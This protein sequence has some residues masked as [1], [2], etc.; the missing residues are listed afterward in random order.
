MSDASPITCRRQLQQPSLSRVGGQMKQVVSWLAA[1]IGEI[2]AR[3]APPKRSRALCRYTAALLAE[4]RVH[5]HNE[6]EIL[7]PVIAATAGPAVDLTP[8][9]DDQLAIQ[10]AA[11]R[12]GQAL[13]SF[14][15]DP[16]MLAAL[17]APVSNLRD[18]LD[19]HT[20]DEEEQ[21]LPAMR[22]YLTVAAYRWCQKQIQRQATLPALRFTAPWLERHAQ[23]D[24]QSQLLAAVG[25]PARILLITTRSRYA[26][27]ERQ[28]FGTSAGPGRQ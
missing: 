12:A 16:R 10:D 4:I 25:W 6:D 19:D 7:W 27:L 2:A 18:M 23:S 8:L 17:H 11:S 20:A 13:T 1:C 26:W 24:E 15:T 22:R 5:H 21:I 14:R 28:V 9:T 3:D